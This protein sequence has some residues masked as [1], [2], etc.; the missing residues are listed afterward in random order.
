MAAD[1]TWNITVNT[2]MGARN[3]TLELKS[4]GDKLEGTHVTWKIAIADP[5]PMT[6]E[7][8]GEIEGDNIKG[9]AATGMFGSFPFTGTRTA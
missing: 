7:F 4:D 8:T 2:P 1:G 6:L 5:M 3:T 9:K